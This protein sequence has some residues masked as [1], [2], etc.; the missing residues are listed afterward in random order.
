MRIIST[1]ARSRAHV[2]FLMDS[3]KEL[4][5]FSVL[6]EEQAGRLMFY[7]DLVEFKEGET[8]LKEGEEG[9]SFYILYRGRVDVR[10]KGFLGMRKTL[11]TL[12]RGDFFGELALIYNQPRSATIVCIETTRCFVLEKDGLDA[13][14]QK[15]PD[16]SGA[17]KDA[18]E[19]RR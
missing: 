12:G 11:A 17:I 2:Q 13:L 14:M 5:I 16:I 8:I 15:N 3:L 7:V 19:K 9:D 4:D 1:A 10:T 18:A 6:S